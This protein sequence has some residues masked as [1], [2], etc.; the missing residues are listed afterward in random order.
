MH[1][2]KAGT[3]ACNLPMVKKATCQR[4]FYSRQ[5]ISTIKFAITNHLILAR[6]E[7]INCESGGE[8][9]TRTR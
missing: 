7:P 3:A 1:D 9:H 4:R 6:R 2:L 8:S 5:R